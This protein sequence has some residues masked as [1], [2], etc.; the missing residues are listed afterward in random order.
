MVGRT[1]YL[2]NM[3][4]FMVSNTVGAQSATHTLEAVHVAL[5]SFAGI[6]MDFA[7]QEEARLQQWLQPC[8]PYLLLMLFLFLLPY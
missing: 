3:M 6:S 2:N 8:R 4:V 7:V 1:P 5:T